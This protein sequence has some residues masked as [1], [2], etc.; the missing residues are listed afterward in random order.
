MKFRLWLPIVIASSIGICAEASLAEES[1][2]I[3]KDSP[4]IKQAI[5]EYEA[6][7]YEAAVPMLLKDLRENGNKGEAHHYLQLALQKLGQP[8][9]AIDE[10]E[11]AAKICPPDAIEAMAKQALSKENLASLLDPNAPNLAPISTTP[12]PPVDPPKQDWFSALSS[13]VA[14]A[15]G[16]KKPESSPSS[17]LDLASS[18]MPDIFGSVRNAAKDAKRWI[19]KSVSKASGAMPHRGINTSADVISMGELSALIEESRDTKW[20]SKGGVQQFDQ[21]PEFSPEWDAWIKKFRR[22]FNHI[23]LRRLSLKAKDETQGATGVVFSLDDSGHLRGAIY[24]S[25]ATDGLNECLMATIHDLTGSRLLTF[26]ENTHIS[27]WNFRMRWNFAK[28]LAV[29][30]HFRASQNLARLAAD[31]AFATVSTD[32][33]VRQIKEAE[34]LKA[35]QMKLAAAKKT[36]I[37]KLT[38]PELQFKTNVAGLILPKAKPLELKAQALRLTDVKL[39]ANSV[40]P[41]PVE[42]LNIEDLP[43]SQAEAIDRMLEGGQ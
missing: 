26:P 12:V 13:N 9:G 6:G 16:M 19:K 33:K 1:V 30:K 5:K 27:G 41:A 40:A 38:Q 42:P 25:T 24:D 43:P 8:E 18:P 39:D 23:L 28:F 10:L 20:Q 15:F 21:A 29:I 22:Q 7:H 36:T 2:I 32:A 34:A 3:K 37:A 4:L 31:S 11:L 14:S 35:Q 17:S